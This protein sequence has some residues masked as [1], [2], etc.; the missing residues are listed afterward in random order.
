VGVFGTALLALL[1]VLQALSRTGR[2]AGG[3]A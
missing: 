3:E 1:D 2:D